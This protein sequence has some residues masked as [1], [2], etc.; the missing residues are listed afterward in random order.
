MFLKVEMV[1]DGTLGPV[2]TDAA[3]R[4]RRGARGDLG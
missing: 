1:A 4:K 3:A 2:F